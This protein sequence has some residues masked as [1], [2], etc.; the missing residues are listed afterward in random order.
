M[1]DQMTE[2]DR[3]KGLWCRG[4]ATIEQIERCKELDR[5]EHRSVRFKSLCAVL[6]VLCAAVCLIGGVVRFNAGVLW[7]GLEG[8]ELWD[9]VTAYVTE[10]AKY[11]FLSALLILLVSVW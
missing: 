4:I 2:H 3:L 8:P 11:S 6:P 9:Y 10:I 5:M 1:S 7:L